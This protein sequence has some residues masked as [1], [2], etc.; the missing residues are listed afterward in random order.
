M[1][2]VHLARE[3]D[4]A[5]DKVW[6]LLENFGDIGWAPGIDKTELIGDGIGMTR[7]LHL[8]GMEPID[9]VLTAM[10]KAAMTFAYDIPRGIPIPVTAYSANAKVTSLGDDRCRVDWYGR[11]E[12]A[13]VSDDDAIAMIQ[14][15][16]E[17]LLQWVGEHLAA[18]S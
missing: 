6:A 1:V 14:G 8:A 10:D 13:G 15:T 3:F 5:A 9:E 11:A 17:M 7:R 2:N 18:A 16:Y 12:P 4:I